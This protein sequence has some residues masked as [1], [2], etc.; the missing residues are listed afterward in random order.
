MSIEQGQY[1]KYLLIY[2]ISFITVKYA[3]SIHLVCS[4]YNTVLHPITYGL[5][6]VIKTNML[7]DLCNLLTPYSEPH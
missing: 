5:L 2:D 1:A 3:I 4:L 7:D 6:I